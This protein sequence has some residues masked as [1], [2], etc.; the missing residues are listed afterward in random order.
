ML[1]EILGLFDGAHIGAN[2]H[3]HH[4]VEA[5]DLHGG[6]ELFGGG[7]LAEL[8]D[9]GGG[10]DGYHLVA[11]QD[12]LDD[13]ENLALVRDG[14]EGAGNQTLA[15]GY[16]LVLVDDGGAVLVLADGI[17]AAGLGAGT[18]QMDDGVVRAGAGA[19][20]ALDALVL[21]N[22]GLTVDEG[23]GAFGADLLAGH[24]QTVLAVLGDLVLVG[25]AGMAGI[26]DDV[27][28]RGFVILLGD[29]GV[30]HALGDQ[31]TVGCGTKTQTHSQADT[32]SG[33]G[34]LQE[35]GVTVQGAVTGDDLVGQFFGTFVAVAGIGHPGNFGE[36]LLTDVGNQ[37]RN[38]SHM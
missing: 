2:S 3:F 37:R 29:G 8:A 13:L 15:A 18:L 5:Q 26:G 22:V 30:V 1:Q 27:D 7:V 11:S 34:A 35:H 21:V 25:G 20:A 12:G 38:A 33:D 17:H 31:H 10:Y 4:L 14:T 9:E 6:N 32:L 19:L 16:A 23:D 36:D 28:Q 24:G